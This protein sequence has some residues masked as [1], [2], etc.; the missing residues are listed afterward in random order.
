MASSRRCPKPAWV[1]AVELLSSAPVPLRDPRWRPVIRTFET[2]YRKA[3]L[4]LKLP[5]SPAMS[6]FADILRPRLARGETFIDPSRLAADP[7]WAAVIPKKA[8]RTTAS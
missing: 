6:V 7:A 3:K 1:V 2:G 8:P 5:F 4:L